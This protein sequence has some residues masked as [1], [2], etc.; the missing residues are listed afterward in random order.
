VWAF[1]R[2]FVLRQGFRD[3][4]HGLM[5]A[6]VNAE[7]TYYKYAKLALLHSSRR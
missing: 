6:I 2:T 1:F 4:K 7:A 3:G 5:L